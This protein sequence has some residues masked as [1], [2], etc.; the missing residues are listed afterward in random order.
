MAE[1][2]FDLVKDAKKRINEPYNKYAE[3]AKAA[4]LAGKLKLVK[5]FTIEPYN[6]KGF[7][8]K[9]GQVVRYEI[10]EGHKSSIRCTW[11][12]VGQPRSGPIHSTHHR[13]VPIPSLRG[14]TF[15]PTARGAGLW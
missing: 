7:E 9:K 1:Q 13:S 5:E 15:T 8:L 6:G 14:F 2:E 3:Q 4:S 12:G 11:S 10:I